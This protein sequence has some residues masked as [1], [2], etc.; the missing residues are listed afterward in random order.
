MSPIA[1]LAWS[2]LTNLILPMG[3]N[4]AEATFLRS[5]KNARPENPRAMSPKSAS[6]SM[7]EMAATSNSSGCFAQMANVSGAQYTAWRTSRAC[8]TLT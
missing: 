1:Q 7:R 2:G 3:F 6:P 5:R 8:S 4:G